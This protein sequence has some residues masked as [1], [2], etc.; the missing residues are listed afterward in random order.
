[1]PQY[2]R[3]MQNLK[4]KWLVLT[5]GLKNDLINLVN[6]HSS[7]QKFE[8]FHFDWLFLSKPYKHWDEKVQ[9]KIFLMTLKSDAK[10][11]K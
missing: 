11:E 2:W 10:F 9:K 1:M 3:V 8:N 6:F 5:C 7:N 4:K